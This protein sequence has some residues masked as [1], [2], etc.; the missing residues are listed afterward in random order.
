MM[1]HDPQVFLKY[2]F[3]LPP[4]LPNPVYLWHMQED[5]IT[6][7]RSI[8]EAGR[9]SDEDLAWFMEEWDRDEEGWVM[10]LL[11]EEFDSSIG[12]PTSGG[13]VDP[14]AILARLHEQMVPPPV[15]VMAV[16]WWSRF[17]K[18][19]VAASLLVSIF[20]AAYFF[21]SGRITTGVNS[22]KALVHVA[23]DAAPGGDRAMLILSGG[24]SIDLDSLG[25]GEIDL[26][27]GPAAVRVQDGDIRYA[28]SDSLP[29][30]GEEAVLHTIVTPRGGQYRL[31]LSDGTRV[32]LNAASSIRYPVVFRGGERRVE[33]TGEAY[34]EVARDE[35]RP[36]LLDADGRALVRVLGTTFNVNTYRDE[37]SLD[38]TLLE[39]SVKVGS[40]EDASMLSLSP[41]RKA[42]VRSNGRII[43][44]EVENMDRVIAWRNG[45]FQFGDGMDIVSIMRQL[46]RWYDVDV[47]YEG[48]V[49][50]LVG[51]SISR[52]ENLSRVLDM[53]GM[54][55]VAEFSIK[56]KVVRVS[57][58]K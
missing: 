14:D 53:I 21:N 38:I 27:D 25:N 56:G 40:T 42:S 24:R 22:S 6:R 3:S 47:E 11:R 16:G 19:A 39:G 2:F 51:G 5:K 43:I 7:L 1:P 34:L 48:D 17:G 32:W 12:L 28:S 8:L 9:W 10:D 31:T 20:L 15:R 58:R 36:F 45:K 18:I 13:Q 44:K 35:S 46:S 57:K 52:Q 23:S 30:S 33:V 50:G 26:G 55:G 54:T 37:P 49:K 29:G 41:G 4:F